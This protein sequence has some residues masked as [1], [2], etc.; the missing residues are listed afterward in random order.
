MLRDCLR[1]LDIG[2]LIFAQGFQLF[3]LEIITLQQ[4]CLGRPRDLEEKP[5]KAVEHQENHGT[6]SGPYISCNSH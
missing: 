4:A 2:Q 6:F 5:S 3:L 1:F